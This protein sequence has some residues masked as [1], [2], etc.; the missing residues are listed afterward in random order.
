M[1]QRSLSRFPFPIAA[2]MAASPAIPGSAINRHNQQSF[3]QLGG[4]QHDRWGYGK[5]ERRGGLAVHDHLELGRE[6]H[7]EVA[8]LLAAQ[9]AIHISGGPTKGVYR[10]GSVG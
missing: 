3:D 8:R 7:R 4:A 6:L 1:V 9:D 5:A 10:V 2:I